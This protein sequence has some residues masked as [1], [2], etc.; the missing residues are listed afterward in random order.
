MM[1]KTHV[2]AGALSGFALYSA[3]P[4]SSNVADNLVLA[5]MTVGG[6]MFGSMFPDIDTPTSKL[7]RKVKPLSSL[8]KSIFGHRGV[9]HSIPF[10]VLIT[11]LAWFYLSNN[12]D[13]DLFYYIKYAVVG[14]DIGFISHIL[15]DVIT[16]E[17]VP[18]FYP[19]QSKKKGFAL[20]L[21]KTNGKGEL[22]FRYLMVIGGVILLF[23]DF[24]FVSMK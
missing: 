10:L 3:L 7:G 13:A 21:M 20:G 2:I 14:F 16:K 12:V 23:K 18:I 11:A 19:L 15:L 6:A 17:K 24:I 8:I 1:F 22:L 4:T 9:T 5:G